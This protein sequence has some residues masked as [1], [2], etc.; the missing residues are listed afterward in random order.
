[1]FG[2]NLGSPVFLGHCEKYNRTISVKDQ[3]RAAF[4]HVTCQ[5]YNSR[6][7]QMIRVLPALKALNSSNQL[8]SPASDQATKMLH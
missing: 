5:G 3:H 4:T 2:S 8:P 6:L 7:L 1:M